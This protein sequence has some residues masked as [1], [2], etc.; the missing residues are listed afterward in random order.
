MLERGIAKLKWH[1]HIGS[2]VKLG[3]AL[4]MLAGTTLGTTTNAEAGKRW[5]RNGGAA[6]AAGIIGFAAGAIAGS[7]MAGPRYY[8]P[9]RGPR[10][11]GPI[12]YAPPRVRYMAPPPVYYAPPRVHYRAAPGTPEWIAYCAR[13]YRSFNP[14]TGTYVTYGGKVRRCR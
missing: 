2:A 11:N 6:A 3:L 8:E 10:Y 1:W 5:H 4:L 9:Y 13:K 7:A 14:R 12:Y